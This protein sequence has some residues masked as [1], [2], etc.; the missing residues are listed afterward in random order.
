MRHLLCLVG[1]HQWQHWSVAGP[2]TW[3]KEHHRTCRFCIK[4]QVWNG[5]F[6]SSRLAE[7]L[8]I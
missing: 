8:V 1:I 5:W 6:Y 3:V 7:K 4:D 2:P